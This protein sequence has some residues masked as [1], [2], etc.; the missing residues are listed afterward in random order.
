MRKQI[1]I[2]L[3]IQANVDLRTVANG[4]SKRPLSRYR[5]GDNGVHPCENWGLTICSYDAA[6]PRGADGDA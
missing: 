3:N 4:V 2:R 6:F 5:F 1:E